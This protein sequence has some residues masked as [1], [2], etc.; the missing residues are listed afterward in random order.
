MMRASVYA[1]MLAL[2]ISASVATEAEIPNASMTAY[3]E[4]RII[5][6]AP[7]LLLDARHSSAAR[8]LTCGPCRLEPRVCE[9]FAQKCGEKRAQLE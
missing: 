5:C 1:V 8:L 4:A 7:V 2:G 9:I 6:F 3:T